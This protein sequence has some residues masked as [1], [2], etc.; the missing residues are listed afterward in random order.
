MRTQGRR[1]GCPGLWGRDE[2]SGRPSAGRLR[3]P[4]PPP[5]HG[6]VGAVLQPGG[7]PY[8]VPASC[9]PPWPWDRPLMAPFPGG[10]QEDRE[11]E[12]GTFVRA[13][14]SNHSSGQGQAEGL[15]RTA[16]SL[17]PSLPLEEFVL[18]LALSSSS[19]RGLCP[20]TR[21]SEAPIVRLGGW[22]AGWGHVSKA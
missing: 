18:S 17:R 16:P 8:R 19:Q 15:V 4:S 11:R 6:A 1:P 3:A 12:E 21:P 20:A 9:L 14:S 22:G 10:R 5:C 2:S 13:P 7:D